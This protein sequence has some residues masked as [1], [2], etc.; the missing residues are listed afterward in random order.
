MRSS[1]SL[2]LAAAALLASWTVGAAVVEDV[3]ARVNGKPLLLSEFKKNLRDV[4]DNYQRNMPQLLRDEEAVKEIRQKTLDQMIEWELL[5]Q[6]AE[7]QQLKVHDREVDK[8]ILEVMERS[9]R[10]DDKTGARRGDKEMEDA[11]KGELQREGIGES[12]YRDRILRQTRIR[13]VVDQEVRAHL[14]EADEERAKKSFDLLL[15]V[16]K[17]DTSVLKGMADEESQA[18]FLFGR[19]LS[20]AHSE[21]VR[22]SHLLIKVPAEATIL[23]KTQAISKAKELKKKL[24]EGADFYEL[25][26]KESDDLESSPRGGDIG[27]ILKG[28]MPPAFEKVAFSLGVGQV[29]EPVDSDFGYHLIRVQEKKA[30]ESITFDKVRPQVAQFLFNLDYDKALQAYVKKLRDKATVELMMPKD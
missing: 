27:F 16:V 26:S 5:Y 20:N 28:W 3:V 21:R 11:F 15:Y 2:A 12:E 13:K 6:K 22:V 14:K 24:D 30:A 9:F 1:N 8:G 19:Q 7:E 25:A 10:V 4:L 18:Y 29:S 17:N 23:E